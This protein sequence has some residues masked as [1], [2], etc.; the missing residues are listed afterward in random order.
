MAAGE[1]YGLEESRESV[2]IGVNWMAVIGE[3]YKIGSIK[4]L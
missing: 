1:I 2:T 3:M 4:N